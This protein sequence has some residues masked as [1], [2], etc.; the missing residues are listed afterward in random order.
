MTSFAQRSR[1]LVVLTLGLALLATAG[2]VEVWDGYPPVPQPVR[3]TTELGA[4]IFPGWYRDKGRG[5]YPI[6]ANL[7]FAFL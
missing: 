7:L 4:Y 6:S 5:D 1:S 3:G 2:E